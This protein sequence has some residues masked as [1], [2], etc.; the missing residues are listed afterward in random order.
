LP[1]ISIYV[2]N[3]VETAEILG[4]SFTSNGTAAAHVQKKT[5]AAR[6]AAFGLA[7]KGFLYPGLSTGTKTFLYNTVVQPT[8]LYG[9]ECISL[10]AANLKALNSLQGEVMKRVCGFNSRSHHSKLLA[11]LGISKCERQVET[12][13]FKLYTSIFQTLSPAKQFNSILLSQYILSGKRIHGTLLDRVWTFN[14][15]PVKVA[16][17]GKGR[18]PMP[19]TAENGVVDSLKYL[20]HSKDFIDINSTDHMLATFLLRSF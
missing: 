17:L 10:S 9:M 20:I 13:T 2:L 3:N 16:F 11:A 5:S 8:L 14:M 18:P 12:R 6:K 4:V 15:S 19:A 7:P 1:I